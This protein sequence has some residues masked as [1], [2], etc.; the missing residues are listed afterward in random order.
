M[1]FSLCFV[2]LTL[3]KKLCHLSVN[4]VIVFYINT[5]I[6]SLKISFK[7]EF[8]SSAEHICYFEE[9]G[10]PNSCWSRVTSIVFFLYPTIQW[11]SNCLVTH[12]LKN[13][14][15]CVQHMK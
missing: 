9:C 14:F 5:I 4:S 15:F 8:L 3:K 1:F 11:T 10:K 13:I 12:I 6:Y 7:P 2:L